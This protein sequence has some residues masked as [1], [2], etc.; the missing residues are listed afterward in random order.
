MRNDGKRK[1][2]EKP[3]G[4]LQRFMLVL[5]PTQFSY[6]S[7]EL[8]WRIWADGKEFTFREQFDQDCFKSMIDYVTKKSYYKLREYLGL[9]YRDEL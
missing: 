1:K 4:K 9:S 3:S 5:E 2:V 8:T 7:H 6:K